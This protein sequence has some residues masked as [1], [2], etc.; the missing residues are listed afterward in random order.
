MRAY[1]SVR[2]RH[3]ASTIALRAVLVANT[4]LLAVIGTASLL[5]YQRPEA[6]VIAAL[7]YGLAG[8]LAVAAHRSDPYRVEAR[9][10]RR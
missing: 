6:Y 1:W 10:A 7:A 4:V 2:H 5:A 3:V 9:R 8:V